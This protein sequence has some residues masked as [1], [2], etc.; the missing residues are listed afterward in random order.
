MAC[1][2]TCF[3]LRAPLFLAVPES[4]SYGI[5]GISGIAMTADGGNVLAGCTSGDYFSFNEFGEITTQEELDTEITGVDLGDKNMMLG[6]KS[7]TLIL[8][9][10][11]DKVVHFTSEPV[12]SVAISDNDACAISGTD[13]N[14]YLFPL[15]G[16][17]VELYVGTPISCVCASPDG[18]K[19]AAA[20]SGSIYLF[21][22]DD[23]VMSQDYEIPS[24]TS[25]AFLRDGSL[26]AGTE[27]GSLYI[28][29]EAVRRIR[30]DLGSIIGLE[31][32]EEVILVSTPT[33]LYVYDSSGME[34]VRLT[35]DNIVDCDISSDGHYIAALSSQ[36]V[37]VFNGRGELL[38]RKVVNNARSVEVSSDGKYMTLATDESIIFLK[39]REDTFRGTR[40]YPYP[41]R[42]LYSFEDLKRVWSY[43]VPLVLT[44][45][46]K[47]QQMGC[48]VGDVNGDGNNEIVV[49]DGNTLLI[50]DSGR[51]VLGEEDAQEDILHIALMDADGDTVPDIFYTVNDGR[52]TVYA[53]DF[54]DGNLTEFDFTA[55]FGVST[56]EKM[57][58][59]LAPVISY[60][61]DEDGIS[62]I[63][64]VVNSGYT[65]HPRGI[66]AFEY[67]SGNV[68]WFY[69][70]AASLVI[71]AFCDID[72]D[73]TPD[74][75]VGSHSCC[76]GCALGDRDDCHA[77]LA[78][79]D[80]NGREVWCKEMA[81]ELQ[82]VRAGVDDIDGDGR[83]EIVGTVYHAS[84][85]HGRLFVMDETG[86]I[87]HDRMYDCSLSPAGICDFDGDGM[88]EIVVTDSNGNINMYNHELELLKTNSMVLYQPSEIEGISDMDGDGNKEIVVKIWDKSVRILSSDFEEKWN[89]KS[90][91]S[92]VPRTLV[93]NVSGCGNDLI[94]LMEKAV[95]LY[96]FERENDD[97]CSG[98]FSLTDAP[99]SAPGA[100][101]IGSSAFGRNYLTL[102]VIVSIMGLI[103]FLAIGRRMGRLHIP[104]F[105]YFAARKSKPVLMV[106]SLERRSETS[107]QM[108]LESVNREIRPAK[109]ARTYTISPQMRSEIIKRV[110]YTSRVI[111]RFLTLRKNPEKAAGELKR[112]GTVIY[113]N[114]VP[115]DF[116]LELTYHYLLLEV[117]DVQIPW[118]LMYCDEFFALKYAISRRIRSEKVLTLQEP[119]KR[120]KKALII[121]DP[122]ET[123]PDAVKECEY[124]TECLQ[125]Y[126]AVTYLEPEK[127][128]KVDV[129]YHFSQGYDIIHYAG[130]LGENDCLPVYRDVLSCAEIERT[131]E[132]SPVV[133]LNGCGSARTFSHNIGGLAKVFLEKGAFS[134]IGSVWN[135]HDRTAADMAGE[136]YKNCFQHPV[137]EALRLAREKCY[138]AGDITWAAFVM[139]GDPTLNLYG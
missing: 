76:N 14:I 92:V 122:T 102:A 46:L 31:T 1:L 70:S 26:V 29:R 8:R 6:T 135:I 35:L 42:E 28:I 15:A 7:G 106:L 138:T 62:E 53:L 44:P 139:Y 113:K 118:E 133:F 98:L 69:M 61:I 50:L 21:T 128:S 129:M 20:T 52:Y 33:T 17:A 66:L 87:L 105:L 132:G 91:D 127:A 32:G 96:S 39:T 22:V 74:I 111:S 67:P 27:T 63:I 78:V 54:A 19:A 24:V 2:V 13:K 18:Q 79:L 82:I 30:E 59:A 119:R 68:E 125:G 120:Q 86:E 37:Q 115:R 60:D 94:I 55:Y 47:Q 11:G 117:E 107:Y 110:D 56:K 51:R 64:A 10:T 48:A 108:S 99:D 45:Y 112:M 123:L 103:S 137:G 116:A 104:G 88:K 36:N 126:Y 73:Q 80:L 81:S 85:L 16:S 49:A 97:V 23:D 41:S 4:W 25:M 65:L 90:S 109:S 101:N 75:I 9:S 57:E 40:S 95:E 34:H 12:L 71:D 114:F 130:E 93:T 134:F 72:G 121:A 136:F 38:W 77:Y 100:E 131:L 43:Q 3:I 89:R 5:D 83:S 58:A 84:H 124:L